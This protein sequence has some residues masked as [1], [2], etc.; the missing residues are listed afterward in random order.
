[1]FL[2][3]NTLLSKLIKARA[4]VMFSKKNTFSKYLFKARAI[5]MFLKKNTFLSKLINARAIVMFLKKNTFSKYLFDTRK[6][7]WDFKSI[8]KYHICILD[9]VAAVFGSC[10]ASLSKKDYNGY[11]PFLLPSNSGLT[12]VEKVK[13]WSSSSANASESDQFFT[14]STI[15]NPSLSG[16]SSAR[17][18]S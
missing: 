4:M 3:K 6:S 11:L 5:V 16:F 7:V 2:T 18:T 15:V 1:M 17:V 9:H 14:I 10:A 8:L 12:M 13:N